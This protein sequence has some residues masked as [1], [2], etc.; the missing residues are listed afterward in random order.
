MRTITAFAVGIAALAL[1]GC[2][3]SEPPVEIDLVAV[4]DEAEE[5]VVVTE[6]AIERVP[7]PEEL[8]GAW[9]LEDLGGRGVMDMVQTTI[10]FDDEGRVSGAAGCNRYTGGYTFSDGV[11]A[12]GPMAAT[13]MMCPEAVMDQE[14]GFLGALGTVDRVATDGP[15]LLIYFT[16]SEMPLRFTRMEAGTGE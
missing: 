7:E 12:F 3:P 4:A 15:F 9:L 2:V 11:L 8:I 5:T 14:D 16:D 6:P 1:L 13:K 10:V